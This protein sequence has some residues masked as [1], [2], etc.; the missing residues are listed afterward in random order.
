[1]IELNV[2]CE[3]CLIYP[4]KINAINYSNDE[5]F[6]VIDVDSLEELKFIA[7]GFQKPLLYDNTH[8]FVIFDK[9]VHYRTK[10]LIF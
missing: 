9:N 5:D 2:E 8:Y 6:V 4:V 10:K 3:K 7:D 1:M